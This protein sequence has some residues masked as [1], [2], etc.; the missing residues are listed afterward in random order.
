MDLIFVFSKIHWEYIKSPTKY[1]VFHWFGGL[2][3]QN[4]AA[5]L[6]SNEYFWFPWI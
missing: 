6:E 4:W 5:K 3:K 1:I 2:I